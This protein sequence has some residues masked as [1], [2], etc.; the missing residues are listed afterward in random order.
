MLYSKG[1]HLVYFKMCIISGEKGCL[2]IHGVFPY[3]LIPLDKNVNVNGFIHQLSEN[4]DKQL[5]K[6]C[7]SKYN[8]QNVFK[9]T[10]VKGM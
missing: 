7:N 8:K 2:H 4:L 9:I 10:Q 1:V 5:N 3:L 6:I